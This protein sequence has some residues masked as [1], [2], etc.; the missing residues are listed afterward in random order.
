MRKVHLAAGV[1]VL[2]ACGSAALVPAA[3]RP[4]AEP[5]ASIQQLMAGVIDPAA[6]AVWASVSSETGPDG[7]EEHFPRTA[8]EWAAL[9]KG[10]L[11]I[12]A[13]A[14]LLQVDGR[15]VSHGQPLEDADVPGISSAPQIRQAIDGNRAAFRAHAGEL[16]A[17]GTA[18]LAAIAARS[19]Q[20]L[21]AAGEK[22]D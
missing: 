22:L 15:P 1:L 2:A 14:K 20:R 11:D 16:Q 8:K 6:D 7:V 5:V 19:P 13:A 4:A 17:A 21:L 10:A 3:N 9:R 18:V 12:V